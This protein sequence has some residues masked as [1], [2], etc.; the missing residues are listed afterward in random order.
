MGQPNVNQ[1]CWF[2][3]QQGSLLPIKNT[4]HAMGGVRDQIWEHKGHKICYSSI[5]KINLGHQDF[6][7]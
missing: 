5:V 7:V 1:F 3:C 4:E 2:E 6:S